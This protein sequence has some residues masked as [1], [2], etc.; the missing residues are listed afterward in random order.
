MMQPS[1]TA[2]AGE[3]HV[4]TVSRL[5]QEVRMLL[6]Q[7]FPLL[8][9]EGEISNLAR[10]RSGHL[11]FSLK[12]EAAQVRCAMFR[13][14]N[15]NLRFQPRDGMQVLLRTRIS[16]YPA[17]GEFQLI[18]EHMEEAGDGALRRAFEALK[19]R[20]DKE[21]LFDPARKQPLPAMP[22]RIGVITSPTGAAVRDV[23]TVLRRRFPTLRVLLYPVPVQG[24]GA[25]PEIAA[26][27]RLACRRRE[28]DALLLTRGGGSLEDLWPFNEETV[29][30]AIHDCTLPLVSAVGHEIDFTIA[31]LVAD[32]R[33][34]T[35]SA[36]AEMLS[37]DGPALAADMARIETR[38]GVLTGQAL[39]RADERLTALARRLQAQHPGRRLQERAQRMD[40]LETRLASA[41]GACLRE[42]RLAAR[43]L[44]ERLARQDPRERI[45]HL[46][47]RNAEARRRLTEAMR[48]A[49][50]LRRQSSAAVA[51]A[52][53]AVSPLATLSR[54]YAIATA[55][56]GRVLR[57]AAE[58]R[59]GE[60]VRARLHHGELHCRVESVA[61]AASC[62]LSPARGGEG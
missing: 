27:I 33:A 43:H 17:R 23:L 51:R 18:V 31:D 13:G 1:S 45:R 40:E 19:A 14:R 9:V 56:D 2:P 20:L 24:A 41:A 8:W 5:N 58:V 11:Y 36:G 52:L 60:A 34:P 26:A 29:A 6:E 39:C 32:R 3:R 48:Q 35:P 28:V 62:P 44:T 47:E 59:T 12:D 42:R 46:E 30:R 53:E 37:P 16:L 50:A 55:E 38:L 21:G 7:A 61:P 10:P 57:D 15:A 25:A 22:R 49:V 4:Y 54:G